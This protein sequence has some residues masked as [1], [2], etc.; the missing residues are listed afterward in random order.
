[1]GSRLVKEGAEHDYFAFLIG[2][3]GLAEIVNEGSISP[4]AIPSV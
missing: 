2:K 3:E 4:Y 1:V